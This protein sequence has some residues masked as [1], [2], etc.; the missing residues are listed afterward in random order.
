[1]TSYN[2]LEDGCVTFDPKNMPFRR[3][4]PTGLRVPLFSIGSCTSYLI[5]SPWTKIDA[6]SSTLGLTIGTKVGTDPAKDIIK[7][8]FE[9]G[10]NLFDTAE[11]YNGGG[12]EFEL[13]VPSVIYSRDIDD[14]DSL[15]ILWQTY[16][17]RIIK[18]LKF[19]RSDIIVTTKIFFGT[20]KGPNDTG[21]S[22]K[23]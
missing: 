14:I 2:A 6:A 10:I 23:Q 12:A 5:T 1:M 15:V 19:R 16:R 8:A 11:G 18:E 3:L 21:L 22:R 7:I 9:N 4:G 13:W 17:G 20:R